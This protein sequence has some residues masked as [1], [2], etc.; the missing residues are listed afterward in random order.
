MLR[1]DFADC[2]RQIARAQPDRW[3][4]LA[5]EWGCRTAWVCRDAALASRP[6]G[7]V[8][9]NY[10]PLWG[11]MMPAS[12]AVDLADHLATVEL[13]APDDHALAQFVDAKRLRPPLIT[14]PNLLVHGELPSLIGNDSRL[15]H[16]GTALVVDHPIPD[17][18]WDRP[19]LAPEAGAP[20]MIYFLATAPYVLVAQGH[21][22]YDLRSLYFTD[23]QL[24]DA[25][26]AWRD[27]GIQLD[28]KIARAFTHVCLAY[29]SARIF[30]TAQKVPTSK[31]PFVHALHEAGT[32]SLV[33]GMFRTLFT[34][35]T[36]AQADL[37]ASHL[38]R[39]AAE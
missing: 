24:S 15:G 30:A 22:G 17:G 33:H 32:H 10:I 31:L 21:N 5:C 11:L 8:V 37:M 1:P 36:R 25:E 4:S 3:I 28:G 12:E 20:V 16:R 23:D 2:L 19:P 34:E 7:P 35:E 14:V 26:R 18:W 6:Y 29:R 27:H 9:D 38:D 39:I 13:D